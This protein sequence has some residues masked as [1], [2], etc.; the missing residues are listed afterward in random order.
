MKLR[1]IIL[2]LSMVM[3]TAILTSC[4]KTK[5]YAELLTEE[6]HA[7]NSF[8]AEHH[9]IGS[10]PA[11]S[12]FLTGPDAPYYQ[13]DAEGNVYM[14]VLDPG[15]PDSRPEPGDRVYF[16]YMRYNLYNYVVGG[17]NTGSGNASNLG[18]SPAYFVFEQLY[19]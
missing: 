3:L 10:I 9:V 17:T 12:V 8:L 1:H 5:S 13:L 6:T 16:R 19:N 7:V 15:D 11:D 4:D 14:Q 18:A 2:S